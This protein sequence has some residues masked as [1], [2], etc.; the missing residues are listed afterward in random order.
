LKAFLDNVG[1]FENEKCHLGG[2]FEGFASIFTLN[3]SN[4]RNDLSKS[5]DVSRKYAQNQNVIKEL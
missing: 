2:G 5:L 1:S 4:L 3:E